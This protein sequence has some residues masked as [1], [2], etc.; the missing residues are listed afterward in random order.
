MKYCSRLVIV[1][2][3]FVYLFLAMLFLA[4]GSQMLILD[5]LFQLKD[6]PEGGEG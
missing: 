2:L 1:L 4:P 5:S 6:E 3:L